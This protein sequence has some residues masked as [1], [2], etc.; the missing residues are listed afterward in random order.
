MGSKYQIVGMINFKNSTIV[1]SHDKS[2]RYYVDDNAK[3]V[4][5]NINSRE[6]IR[7]LLNRMHEE[8]K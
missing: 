7:W 1:V 4:Q 2:Y 3:S 5:R 8:S 6:C